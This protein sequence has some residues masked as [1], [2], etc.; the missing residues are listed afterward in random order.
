MTTLT[1]SRLGPIGRALAGTR[2][3]TLH[4]QTLELKDDRGTTEEMYSV[5]NRGTLVVEA[6][7]PDM[8]SAIG[9][10][11]RLQSLLNDARTNSSG[12]VEFYE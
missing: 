12:L 11:T 3:Y 2:D 9:A 8:P 7:L 4:Q 1:T 6:R 5:R 10:L